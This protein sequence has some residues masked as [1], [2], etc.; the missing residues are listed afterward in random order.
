MI[1]FQ[2][3]MCAI[4]RLWQARNDTSCGWNFRGGGEDGAGCVAGVR[5]GGRS[6]VEGRAGRVVTRAALQ[7]TNKQQIAESGAAVAYDGWHQ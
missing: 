2:K 1:S 5:A 7:P 3:G 4:S 6:A